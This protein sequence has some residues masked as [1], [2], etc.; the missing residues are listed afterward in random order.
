MVTHVGQGANAPDRVVPAL[1][2]HIQACLFDLDGVLTQTARLHAA[3]WKHM[4]DAFLLERS[5]QTG[6]PFRPFELPADYTAYVDGKLRQDG[7][8]AFLA[9]RGIV[10]PEGSPDDPPIARWA[11]TRR[12]AP[13]SKTR[14][15]AS[16]LDTRAGLAGSSAWTGSV[17]LP[18]SRA[19][20]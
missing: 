15:L 5:R 10:L 17:R 14:W 8:R 1:P 6:E 20:A 13:C 12:T 18:C 2:A 11:W 3:A 7:V 4:F 19:T 9:T 16:R